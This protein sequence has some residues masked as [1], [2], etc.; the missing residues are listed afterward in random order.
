MPPTI[1]KLSI[2]RAKHELGEL[3]GQDKLIVF[4]GS[5][6]SV[7]SGLPNWDDFLSQFIEYA[8][9]LVHQ[10][11][12]PAE[13]GPYLQILKSARESREA[14]PTEVAEVVKRDVLE[15][16]EERTSQNISGDLQRWFLATFGGKT[17]NIYHKLLTATDYP[18]ILTSNYD[19]LFG[20][21][22]RDLGDMHLPLHTYTFRDASKIVASLYSSKRCLVHIHGQAHDLQLDE[23][24]FTAK[25]YT[26]MIAGKYQGFRFCLESLF[27][28]Y[29]T[30]FLGYGLSDPHLEDLVKEVSFFLGFSNLTDLP[31]NYLVVQ[32][33]RAGEVYQLYKNKLRTKLIVFSDDTITMKR[34]Y[35]DLLTYLHNV[36]PVANI[37]QRKFEFG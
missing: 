14:Y 28:R 31:W 16:M 29:S 22:A 24:V 34:Q 25:D 11:D 7:D 5:G 23:I 21:A 35:C 32:E 37:S 3:V 17:P 10:L 18:C 12:N 36:K 26:Q 15:D 33:K 20:R 6:M 8:S 9:D 27:V 30:L 1:E 2:K 19:D 4:A 13:R